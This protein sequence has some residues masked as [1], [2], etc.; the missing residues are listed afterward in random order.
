MPENQK[1][2][3]FIKN[4][5]HKHAV[6]DIIL[7]GVTKNYSTRPFERMHGKL[8]VIYLRQTNFKDVAQQVSAN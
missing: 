1:D 2:W 7:K 5:T 3:N 8:K 4:H 6:S